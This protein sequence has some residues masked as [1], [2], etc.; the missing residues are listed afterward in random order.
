MEEYLAVAAQNL[1]RAQE[2]IAELGIVEAWKSVNATANLIGSVKTG[3]L[4]SHL[5]IDFHVYSQDFC[6]TD[7]FL[8]I[9]KIAAHQNIK[10]V[11]YYNFL[12]DI[13]QSLDWHLHYTD[14][15]QRTWRIDIIHLRN[16][17]PY[18]GKFERITQKIYAALTPDLK[19]H[20]LKIKWD[21]AHR[22]L[23]LRGIEVYKAVIQ[24]H[25]TTLDGFLS[26]KTEQRD[27]RIVMWEPEEKSET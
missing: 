4:M 20:I 8:A 11:S 22:E 26:W 13:D 12:E 24:D 2:I 14:R 21:G 17:S 18:A 23:K 27:E 9:G 16:E 1:R 3:L 10:K 6:I 5:D 25:I 15:E 19:K 7:S